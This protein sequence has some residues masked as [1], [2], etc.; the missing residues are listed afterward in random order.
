[1]SYLIAF[2]PWAAF[3][4]FPASD[5]KWAAIFALA[6]SIIGIT[7][8]TRSG[9]PLDAQVIGIGSA[10]YFAAL[11]AL[12]FAD[13]H[14]PLHAYTAS[15]GSGALGLIAGVSL[16]MRKPFTLGIAKQST[17]RE[18][19]DSPL[20]IRTN[21]VITA[22]WA[23]SLIAGSAV[24]AILAH[25]SALARVIVQVATFVVPLVFTVRYAARVRARSRAIAMA[26]TA[27]QA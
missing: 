11:T 24:L 16:A 4:V 1:M 19:W 2:A 25:S 7:R 13:P 18:Y 27:S 12:A 6:I 5:W 9:T 10:V 17:P 20:F 15:L 14:T 21:M 22:A 3:A 26:E 8:Q 23:A